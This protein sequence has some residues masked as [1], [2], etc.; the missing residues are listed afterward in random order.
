MR[1]IANALALLTALAL[2][3]LALG[4]YVATAAPPAAGRTRAALALAIARHHGAKAQ[5]TSDPFPRTPE[6]PLAKACSCTPGCT[7]GCNTGQ[8]CPCQRLPVGP[9]AFP[10]ACPGGRCV[11][12]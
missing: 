2:A 9:L 7:C 3:W 1:P 4:V 6:P 12:H 11:S 8:V 10:A 5:P